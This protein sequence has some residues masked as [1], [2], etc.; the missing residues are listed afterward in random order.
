V[1]EDIGPRCIGIV[2]KGSA[3]DLRKAEAEVRVR[4]EKISLLIERLRAAEVS[5]R[6][7]SF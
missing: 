7:D 3:K 2:D 4:L 6:I 5:G 1:H